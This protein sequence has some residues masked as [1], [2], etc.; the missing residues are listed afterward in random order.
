MRPFINKNLLTFFD[1][2]EFWDNEPVE[3][4]SRAGFKQMWEAS[5]FYT[6][7]EDEYVEEAYNRLLARYFNTPFGMLDERQIHLNI[8]KSIK[9]YVPNLV[10]RKETYDNI[11]N[12][13]LSDLRTKTNRTNQNQS[14]SDSNVADEGFE[15]FVN[16]PNTTGNVIEP[17]ID[18]VSQ[19]K[20]KHMKQEFIDNRNNSGSETLTTGV[21]EAYQI[22][23]NAIVDG[24]WDELIQKFDKF[25]VRLYSGAYDYIYRNE[26]EEG[27][28]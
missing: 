11:Y 7:I 4:V 9:D 17:I 15:N 2:Y 5:P 1:L 14:V 26:I 27:D 24:L 12:T 28:E 6:P 18:A 16:A 22:R 23:L 8:F 20:N 13:E 3:G 10:K 21:S 19:Q 25:F